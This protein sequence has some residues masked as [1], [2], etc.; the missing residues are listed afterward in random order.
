MAD[1]QN[2]PPLLKNNPTF[3]AFLQLYARNRQKK[4]TFSEIL[5]GGEGNSLYLDRECVGG[6]G[7]TRIQPLV[8]DHK[9]IL[10]ENEVFTAATIGAEHF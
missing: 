7:H 6:G 3:A 5:M 9:G 10:V 8:N 4:S 2:D 1:L